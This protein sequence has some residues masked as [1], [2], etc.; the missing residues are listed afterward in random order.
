MA[1]VYAGRALLSLDYV[2]STLAMIFSSLTYSSVIALA[3]L[4]LLMASLGSSF[5]I[6]Y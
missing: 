5:A 1:V 6:C 2:C 4:S 3:F